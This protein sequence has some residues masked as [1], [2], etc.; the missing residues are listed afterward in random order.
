[1]PR[2]VYV[3]SGP[4]HS[5]FV[6]E[7]GGLWTNATQPMPQ[8]TDK[9]LRLSKIETVFKVQITFQSVINVK[10]ARKK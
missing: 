10:S 6:D 8:V 3:S 9:K 4:T 1:M 5:L 2:I 7:L